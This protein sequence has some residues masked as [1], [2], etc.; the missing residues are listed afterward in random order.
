MTGLYFK[1]SLRK[2]GSTN[3]TSVLVAVCQLTSVAQ[4]LIFCSDFDC[5]PSVRKKEVRRSVIQ[6]SSSGEIQIIV[7]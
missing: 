5:P 7:L 3:I 4:K 1:T 2:L 6:S